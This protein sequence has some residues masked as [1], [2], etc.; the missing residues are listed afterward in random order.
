MAKSYSLKNT[1]LKI[2]LTGKDR[3]DSSP[4]FFAFCYWLY[5]KLD[6]SRW[7]ECVLKFR[8]LGD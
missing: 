1:S 6:F 2:K 8:L 7:T 3:Y 5:Y 4:F